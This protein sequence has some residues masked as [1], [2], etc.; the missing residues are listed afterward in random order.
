LEE[1]GDEE[2]WEDL[3]SKNRLLTYEEYKQ[4]FDTYGP[5]TKMIEWN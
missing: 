3:H 1:E 2:E 4:L 5:D